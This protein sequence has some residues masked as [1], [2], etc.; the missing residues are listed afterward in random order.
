MGRKRTLVDPCKLLPNAERDN[1]IVGMTLAYTA[2]RHR[3]SS[4]DPLKRAAGRLRLRMR[5]LLILFAPFMQLNDS[6]AEGDFYLQSIAVD[7]ASR[8]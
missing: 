2:E 7:K 6:I 1:I 5:T 3:R 8:V 4:H